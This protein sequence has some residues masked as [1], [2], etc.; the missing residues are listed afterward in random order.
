MYYKLQII[1]C[2]NKSVLSILID[3]YSVVM[4]YLAHIEKSG[5]TKYIVWTADIIYIP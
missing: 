5:K 1:S 2:L 4:H 3:K